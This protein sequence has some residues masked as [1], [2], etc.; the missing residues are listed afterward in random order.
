MRNNNNNVFQAL[1]I[2]AIFAIVDDMDYEIPAGVA[3][4]VRRI[5][6]NEF[7]IEDAKTGVV[8]YLFEEDLAECVQP[9]A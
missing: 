5:S 8:T 1:T 3:V 2:D 6:E 4:Q 9:V 7:E